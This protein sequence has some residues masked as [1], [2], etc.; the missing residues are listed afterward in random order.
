MVRDQSSEYPVKLVKETNIGNAE[1][2][3]KRWFDTLNH[4]EYEVRMRPLTKR[5]IGR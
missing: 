4:V 3:G 2:K 1:E 5:E